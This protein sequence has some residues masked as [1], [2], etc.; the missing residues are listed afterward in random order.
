MTY[1][2]RRIWVTAT[3]MFAVGTLFLSPAASGASACQIDSICRS[4]GQ[5]RRYGPGRPAD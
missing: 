3:W 1:V 4:S 2:M 5:R